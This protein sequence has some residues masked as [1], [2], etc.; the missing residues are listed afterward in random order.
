MSTVTFHDSDSPGTRLSK[1]CQELILQ[2]PGMSQSYALQLVR[3]KHPD[4]A[5]LHHEG[6]QEEPPATVD[7]G[8]ALNRRA[9]TLQQTKQA[10]SFAEALE[11]AMREMPEAAAAYARGQ[12]MPAASSRQ[13]AEPAP[14]RRSSDPAVEIQHLVQERMAADATLTVEQAQRQVLQHDPQLARCYSEAKP[15]PLTTPTAAETMVTEAL[16][17]AQQLQRE[18]AQM[19]APPARTFSALTP[20]EKTAFLRGF[21]GY[22]KVARFSAA[23]EAAYRRGAASRGMAA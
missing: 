18:L 11:I 19:V 1:Y 16:V 2:Y 7:P 8:E 21:R 9:W 14:R 23:E 13:H 12:Y 22:A 20:A 17:R 10:H 6:L 4:L 3:E 15:L 5:R